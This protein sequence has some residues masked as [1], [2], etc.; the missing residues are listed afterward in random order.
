MTGRGTSVSSN[1]MSA[2][3]PV[4]HIPVMLNEV[5]LA[6]QPGQGSTIVDGTFGA[7]GYSR[8]I[9]DEGANVLAIDRDP[10]AIA[11]GQALVKEYGDRLKLVTGRFSEIEQIARDNGLSMVDGVV[12]DI[13]VSS[14]QIDE[15]ERGF[16]FAKDGPLD[17]RMEQDGPSA[18]DVVNN[19]K[20]ADLTRII[21]ILGEERQASRISGAI[22]RRRQ[23]EPFTRTLELAGVVEAVLGRKAGDRIHPA[24][25]TFQALRIF[26]NRELDQ[27]AEA[28][29]A[30]E[31]ILVAGG[32]PVVV[33]FH[34]LEDR[35]VKRFFADRTS[36]ASVSR[37]LPPAEQ[38]AQTFKIEKRGAITASEGEIAE[39]PRSR[40]A[41]LR[42]AIRTAAE[43]REGDNSIFGLPRL[44][45]L[46]DFANRGA[47]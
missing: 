39:N 33:T 46:D 34:S 1:D 32:R 24:T 20:Q 26:V 36:Q 10:S 13:G 7:G 22:T 19:A 40:S 47:A 43:A 11:S 38:K 15:A 21:G 41:K 27:L 37:H 17:M 35:I 45:T 44:A 9:L 5:L 16:S 6:L 29:H 28:L 4:R 42:Y 23:S 2:G 25:R 30:A 31:R 14:M 8:A 12:L 3:G 18:A